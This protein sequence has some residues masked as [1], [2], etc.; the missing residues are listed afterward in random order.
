MGTSHIIVHLVWLSAFSITPVPTE[1]RTDGRLYQL[2]LM[3]F[4]ANLN[5]LTYVS[6]YS[7]SY[8]PH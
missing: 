1:Q 2:F 7:S 4:S 3:W 8:G 6:C 5:I